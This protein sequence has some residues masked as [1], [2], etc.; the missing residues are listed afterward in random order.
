MNIPPRGATERYLAT[1]GIRLAVSF[2]VD[3]GEL[4]EG[5][6]VVARGIS[7]GGSI[8]VPDRGDLGRLSQ[9]VRVGDAVLQVALGEI[10]KTWVEVEDQ[11]HYEFVPGIIRGEPLSLWR[12][13]A[14]DDLGS[15]YSRNDTGAFDCSGGEASHGLRDLGG[16]IPA[17]ASF[18]LLRFSS[19]GDWEPPE[20]WRRELKLDLRSGS[21]VY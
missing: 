1:P 21:V 16:R 15:E 9:P 3:L 2:D 11:L 4:L 17:E 19:G 7:R 5:H 12:M 6:H 8:E 13:T 10:Q 18:L 20:P 14:S